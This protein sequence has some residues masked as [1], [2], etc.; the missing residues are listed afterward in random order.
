MKRILLI[1]GFA[2]GLLAAGA[3]SFDFPVDFHFQLGF[4]IHVV[5]GPNDMSQQL[6]LGV[7]SNKVLSDKLHSLVVTGTIVNYGST[8]VEGVDMD[9][10]V[11]SYIGTGTSRGRAVVEPSSIPPGG[12]A[13]FSVHMNLDSPK[14][15]YAM[16]T[17]T[18]VPTYYQVQESDGGTVVSGETEQDTYV[19]VP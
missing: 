1:L 5:P 11:T 12:T 14:P 9:F 17:I 3:Q 10:A 2:A 16:Y 7:T 13:S 19:V 18:G 15:Q 8:P 6:G 4:T